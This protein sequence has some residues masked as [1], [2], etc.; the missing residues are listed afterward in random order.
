MSDETKADNAGRV[1]RWKRPDGS[2]FM[3]AYYYAFDPTG[4]EVVDRILSAVACAGKCAHHTESWGEHGCDAEIQREAQL[5][6][7]E[8]ERLTRELTDARVDMFEAERQRDAAR[9]E[10]DRLRGVLA[11]LVR[12]FD[13]GT[14][15]V[16]HDSDELGND[17]CGDDNDACDR[18]TCP[19]VW[20]I[21]D[22]AHIA[23]GR[24]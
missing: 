13:A 24:K 17:V 15:S 3:S 6:A 9:A 2:Y 11:S 16:E 8:V 20:V 10:V 7:S 12:C 23:R 21:N 14:I 4:C 1:D 19:A 18:E 5:A 22:A